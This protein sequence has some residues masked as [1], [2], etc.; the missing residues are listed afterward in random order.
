MD[1]F[2]PMI[3]TTRHIDFMQYKQIFTP[4]SPHVRTHMHPGTTPDDCPARIAFPEADRLKC[5][6]ERDQYGN[7]RE[8]KFVS[9]KHHWFWLMNYIW[10]GLPETRDFTGHIVFFEEDHVVSHN[11]YRNLQKLAELKDK[12]CRDSCL[13]INMGPGVGDGFTK[14]SYVHNQGASIE[15]FH[16]AGYGFNRKTWLKIK[17]N[18]ERFCTFGDY[19]WDYSLSYLM[20]V[21]YP[22][23]AS[24][25][26]RT[27]S[28]IHI[29]KCGTHIKSA[30]CD[31]EKDIKIF[32]SGNHPFLGENGNIEVFRNSVPSFKKGF[33]GWGGWGDLRD[34]DLCRKFTKIT[35]EN[36]NISNLL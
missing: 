17:S 19:N 34:H 7:Y 33:S 24:I 27:D 28:L 18:P 6:G 16:N 26:T 3:D 9:L 2:Q 29:G 10:D 13:F 12:E 23:I 14:A 35:K 22:N 15:G 21:W 36:P 20:D 1:F 32:Q 30:D 25:M 8:A 4:Y 11:V 31:P 5:K